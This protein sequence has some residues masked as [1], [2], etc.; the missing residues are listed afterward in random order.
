MTQLLVVQEELQFTILID[1]LN[2]KHRSIRNF[3]Y[4][5]MCM[6]ESNL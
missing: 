3:Y 1:L 4:M 2:E 5:S 6:Y